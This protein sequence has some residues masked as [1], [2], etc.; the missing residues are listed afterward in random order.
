MLKISSKTSVLISEF[1]S[2]YYELLKQKEKAFRMREIKIEVPVSEQDNQNND[3]Q[4]HIIRQS[5][6]ITEIQDFFYNFFQIKKNL[7]IQQNV[8]LHFVNDAL[9]I[10]VTLTDEVFMNM[11]WPGAKEWNNH[12]L[13][14]RI[15]QT[16]I[17]GEQIFKKIDTLLASND[18]LQKEISVL[19]MFCL[20]LGF[21]GEY[22]GSQD[23]EKIAY[24]KKQLYSFI[25]NKPSNIISPG[26]DKLFPQLYDLTIM[27]SSIK[28]LPN[29]RTWFMWGVSI[30]LFYI[31]VTY[32]VWY[33]FSSEIHNDINQLF[34]QTRQGSSV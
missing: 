31:F 6:Y 34:Q 8:G 21:L 30:L 12:T 9:Y 26:R 13:E 18:P 33:K 22:R 17:A 1:Q 29:L 11:S 3:K 20:G 16:Q 27:E 24:Y 15:F 10:M 19:Y 7:L 5:W 23:L 2:F 28:A 4:D 32:G 14:G 25:H